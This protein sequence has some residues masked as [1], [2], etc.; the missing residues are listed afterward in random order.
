MFSDTGKQSASIFVDRGM[1]GQLNGEFFPLF[2]FFVYFTLSFTSALDNINYKL[3]RQLWPSNPKLI[4]LFDGT[5]AGQSVVERVE[6]AELVCRLCGAKNLECVVPMRLSGGTYAV[7]QQLN[8]EKRGDFAC[9]KDVL[10]TA[11]AL[12]PVTAYKQFAARRAVCVWEKRW[13]S[14][15]RSYAGS[16]L[17]SEV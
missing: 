6:K 14:F 15:W 10:Y 8:E 17:S 13:M 5:D 3:F 16:Q 4:L 9:I 2:S 1:G 12:S 11:F 7:Y